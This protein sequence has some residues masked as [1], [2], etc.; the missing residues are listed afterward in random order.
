M[1]NEYRVPAVSLEVLSGGASPKAVIHAVSM[2]VLYQASYPQPTDPS[3][4]R[5]RSTPVVQAPIQ[6][7]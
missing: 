3:R 1:A 5:R 4:R 6:S 7:G 2:E